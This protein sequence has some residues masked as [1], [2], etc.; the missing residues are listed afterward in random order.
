VE[1]VSINQRLSSNE[2][3]AVGLFNMNIDYRE[4]PN[5]KKEE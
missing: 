4:K 1:D 2:D 3:E 5:P